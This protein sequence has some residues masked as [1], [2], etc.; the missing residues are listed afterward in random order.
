ME[1]A[2]ITEYGK[3]GEGKVCVISDSL[4]SLLICEIDSDILYFKIKHRL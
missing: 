1:Y 3:G 2:Q 4:I